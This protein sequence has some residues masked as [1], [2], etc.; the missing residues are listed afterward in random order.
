MKRPKPVSAMSETRDQIVSV[1]LRAREEE[2][3]FNIRDEGP[4]FSRKWA[5]K[6]CQNYIPNQVLYRTPGPVASGRFHKNKSR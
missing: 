1:I 2:V 3:V 5:D 6:S 4:V